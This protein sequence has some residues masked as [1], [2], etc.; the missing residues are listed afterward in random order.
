MALGKEVEEDEAAVSEDDQE[1]GGGSVGPAPSSRWG[2]AP[3]LFPSPRQ[4]HRSWRAWGLLAFAALL[5]VAVPAHNALWP[6]AAFRWPFQAALGGR[7]RDDGVTSLLAEVPN[8]RPLPSVPSQPLPTPRLASPMLLPPSVSPPPVPLPPLPPSPVPL[9]LAPVATPAAPQAPLA[10]AAAVAGAANEW[11]N[12]SSAG[13]SCLTTLCCTDPGYQCFEKNVDFAACRKSCVP[14]LDPKDPDKFRTEWSCRPLASEAMTL[15]CFALAMPDTYEVTLLRTLYTKRMGMF[16]CNYWTAYSSADITLGS[17][18]EGR[19]GTRI[20][21]GDMSATVGGLYMTALNTEVFIKVWRALFHDGIF[22]KAGWTVK[23]DP[24][25]VF[26]PWRLR[27][28]LMILSSSEPE[29]LNNCIAGMH[30]P[31]EIVSRAAMAIFSQNITTC[32]RSL[33]SEYTMFGED[34]IVRHCLKMLGVR[35]RDDFG[36]LSEDHCFENPS[37]CLSGKVAFHPFKTPQSYFACLAQA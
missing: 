10:I 29:Y 18:P 1:G 13:H 4:R 5:V 17:G 35:R 34:V 33:S 31:I 37:P 12:C 26:L 6:A 21:G 25:A 15:Y 7:R 28:H 32:E 14:G 11:G 27:R 23:L 24:D 2:Y 20:I 3:P 36:L 19:V 22:W 9:G 30:G 16:G 8:V